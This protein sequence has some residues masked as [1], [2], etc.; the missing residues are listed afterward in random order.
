MTAPEQVNPQAPRRGLARIFHAMLISLDGLR[1]GW[2]EAAF[3]QEVAC[4]VVMLPAAFV[5]G[6]GWVEI[7]LLW[8]VVVLVMVVELINSAIEAVVDRIGPQWHAL[9]K[10]AKDL[11]SAAVMLSLLLCAGVWL[12]ALWHRFG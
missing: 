9:S 2:G 5:V 10:A 12:A 7:A 3:R 1:A 8:A 11:G 4:A 6:R